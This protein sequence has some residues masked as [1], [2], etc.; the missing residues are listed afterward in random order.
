ML[1]LPTCIFQRDAPGWYHKILSAVSHHPTAL[2]I[3]VN[4]YD[5]SL[6]LHFLFTFFSLLKVLHF[7]LVKCKSGIKHNLQKYSSIFVHFFTSYDSGYLFY[8]FHK[9]ICSIQFSLLTIAIQASDKR[10][11]TGSGTFQILSSVSDHQIGTRIVPDNFLH[12]LRL[13]A[14]TIRFTIIKLFKPSFHSEF[15]PMCFAVCHFTVA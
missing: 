3:P 12:D 4:F 15:F 13:R 10:T 8:R 6:S 11:F 1:I 7:F 2:W 5:V 9:I 14:E